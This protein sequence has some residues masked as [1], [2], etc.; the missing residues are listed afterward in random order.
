MASAVNG[1]TYTI[2]KQL[3]KLRLASNLTPEYIAKKLN[4]TKKAY[5]LYERASRRPTLD[6]LLILSDF[7]KV[8]LDYFARPE[9]VNRSLTAPL[10][11]EDSEKTSRLPSPTALIAYLEKI[12]VSR[13]LLFI[14]FCDA[15][16]LDPK[17]QLILRILLHVLTSSQDHEAKP[18]AAKGNKKSGSKSA[19]DPDDLLSEFD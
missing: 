12:S 7:Y 5:T 9:R 13:E 3:N 10:V 17:R 4:I 14:V 19:S 15:F 11:F 1:L 18:A 6:S 2:G 16:H 8:P